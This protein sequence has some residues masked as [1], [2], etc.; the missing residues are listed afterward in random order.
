M[1]SYMLHVKGEEYLRKL[2]GQRLFLTRDL[3]LLAENLAKGRV[4]L[5]VGIGY[6]ESLPF[7]KAGLPVHPL[8]APREGYYATGGYGHLT[9]L[10]DAP[11]P[12]ATRLFVNW[13]M[14]KEGQEIFSR[15][16]GA[17]T[18]RLDVDT[19]WL[20]E[21]AQIGAKD[22]LTLEQY[23]RMENQSEEMIYKVRDPGA[24]L[25]RRLLD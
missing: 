13:L 16:M 1:W 17:A 18:R 2:V 9:I 11:H 4:G 19:K 21:F 12:N 15:G 7:I 14:G 6:S 24:A 23:R 20:K 5:A 8:P 22:G 25:A 10:K 3:R